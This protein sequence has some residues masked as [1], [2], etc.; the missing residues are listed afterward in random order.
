MSASGRVMKSAFV[1][2]LLFAAPS[3]LAQAPPAGCQAELEAN[4]LRLRGAL[5]RLEKVKNATQRE[6]CSAYWLHV[7]DMERARDVF[8]RCRTGHARREEVAHMVGSIADWEEIIKE[9]CR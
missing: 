6:K 4:G 7:R 9:K 2:L 8:M 5:E 3:A 1:A